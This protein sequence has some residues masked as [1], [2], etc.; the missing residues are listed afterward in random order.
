MTEGARKIEG[1]GVKKIGIKRAA[2]ENKAGSKHGKFVQFKTFTIYINNNNNHFQN[3]NEYKTKYLPKTNEIYIYNF[4]FSFFFL[5]FLFKDRTT[6]FCSYF[7][8]L[9]FCVSIIA[10]LGNALKSRPSRS[11]LKRLI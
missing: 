8:R 1:R 5:P 7:S 4:F 3:N 11:L 6:V 2:R 10:S 9:M